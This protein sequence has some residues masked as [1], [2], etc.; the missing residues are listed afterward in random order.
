[1]R[2][3]RMNMTGFEIECTCSQVNTVQTRID[4]IFS[5]N[6]TILIVGTIVN[7]KCTSGKV[8]VDELVNFT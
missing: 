5:K 4:T 6:L 1:M 7:D 2:I 8:D 3:L